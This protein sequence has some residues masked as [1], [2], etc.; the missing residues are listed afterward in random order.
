MFDGRLRALGM[1]REKNPRAE[2]RGQQRGGVIRNK[3]HDSEQHGRK[4]KASAMPERERN[5]ESQSGEHDEHSLRG[6]PRFPSK[7]HQGEHESRN[8]RP[9]ERHEPLS[10]HDS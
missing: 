10:E 3:R 2:P 7:P 4:A 9:G 8:K 6:I 5:D 1:N